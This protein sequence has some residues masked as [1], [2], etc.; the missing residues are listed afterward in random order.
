MSFPQPPIEQAGRVF[1]PLRGIF[2]QLGASVVYQSGVINAT[3][4]GRT[5]QLTIGS[6][7]ATI[8]GQPATLDSP[9]FVTNDSTLVPL[10][11]IAT[12]LGASVNWNNDTSTVTISGG[13]GGPRPPAY[14]RPPG[15][16]R[17]APPPNESGYVTNLAPQGEARP[18]SPISASFAGPIQRNSL[19]VLIDGSDVSGQ[20]I[21]R[22]DS[23]QYLTRRP[24][25]PGRHRVEVSGRT[26]SGAPF[27]T[28]WE[29]R[30]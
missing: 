3:G 8:N 4:H 26:L 28:S 9:P 30:I 12:A 13:G 1:V 6:T 19:R 22:S 17:P 5:V 24:L 2:E 21:V 20:L 25:S 27:S 16:N 18:L 15:Y 29:F 11:F 10:R 7:N 23:F 14:N